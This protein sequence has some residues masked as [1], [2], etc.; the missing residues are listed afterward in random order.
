MQKTLDLSIKQYETGTINGG[1]LAKN[2]K[3]YPNYMDNGAWLAF[4][5]DMENNYPSVFSEYGAGSGGELKEKGFYPPKM[6]SYGSSSRM[7]YNL[8]KEI[9]NFH[10]E[11]KLPTRVGGIANLD[12]FMECDDRFIFVE[13]KCREP[14][15]EKPH[16]VECKYK[17]LYAYINNDRSCNLNIK[18]D[19]ADCKMRVE[20][21]VGTHLLVNFDIKQMISHLLGIA[22]KFINTPAEK[23]ILFLYL[24]YNPKHI[25]IVSD[26]KRSEI[27]DTY[28]RMCAECQSI[29]FKSLFR[30]ILVYLVCVLHE[31]HISMPDIEKMVARFSVILC[32]Q[33]DCMNY[34][35]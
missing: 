4:K 6:A 10:F 3:T 17:D 15:G 27:F 16:L 5:T 29:D 23:E 31:S 25:S 35:K 26:K 14:Y 19:D 34:I 2:N 32:D 8:C 21:S 9:P 30:S 22:I 28:D 33:A 7:I 20:F 24:C 18:T 13:A 1:Y 11:Y 12:G